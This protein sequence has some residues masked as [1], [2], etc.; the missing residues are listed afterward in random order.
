MNDAHLFAQLE[1]WRAK[2]YNPQLWGMSNGWGLIL[3]MTR[4]GH[5]DI[6]DPGSIEML[7]RFTT[8][9][10]TTPQEAIE[11]AMKVIQP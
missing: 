2:G 4:S 8:G 7:L 3:D 1:T 11:A 10:H 6:G 5:R 9:I